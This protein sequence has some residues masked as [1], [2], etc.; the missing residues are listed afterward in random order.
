M[1]D[2]DERYKKDRFRQCCQFDND[3]NKKFKSDI[4][5]FLLSLTIKKPCP[6][7]W[8]K[9]LHRNTLNICDYCQLS[10]IDQL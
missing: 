5:S 7:K 10:V 9:P 2:N 8:D 4:H 1:D 6:A 3:D